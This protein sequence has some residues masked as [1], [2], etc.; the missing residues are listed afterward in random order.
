MRARRLM[1]RT[2]QAILGRV[3]LRDFE[4]LTRFFVAIITSPESARFVKELHYH[5]DLGSYT[6]SHRLNRDMVLISGLSHHLDR[7]PI[8]LEL[9]IVMKD[10]LAAELGNLAY[11]PR[12]EMRFRQAMFL[13]L[14]GHLHSLNTVCITI[15]G[16]AYD[17]LS[18]LRSAIQSHFPG[19]F[20]DDEPCLYPCRS[21]CKLIFYAADSY[22]LATVWHP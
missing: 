10:Q 3:V 8:S 22:Q 5:V 7:C 6:S 14:L 12:L 16:Q 4:A 18:W 9:L 19:P 21:L 1:L 2:K 11:G 17:N 13:S 20:A 15:H